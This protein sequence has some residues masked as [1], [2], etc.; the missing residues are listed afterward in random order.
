MMMQMLQAGGL[1]VLTDNL[2]QADADNPQGYYEFERVK[3]LPKGDS[4]WLAEAEGK[5][6]KVIS[7]LLEHLPPGYDYRVIF[8][9][10]QMAEIMASQR[11]ML[12][13][14]GESPG[15]MGDEQ[16]TRLFEKHL[17]KVRAWLLAQPNI[18]LLEVDYNRLLETPGPYLRQI[19]EFLG[20]TLDVA[21]MAAV[22]D[23]GLYRSRVL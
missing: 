18:A 15:E 1:A 5:A 11:R 2:R 13:H 17:R 19:N 9:H 22:V 6:V 16:L 21:K 20:G 14:R 4:G 23:P 12:A 7:A 8:M 10:R 3:V